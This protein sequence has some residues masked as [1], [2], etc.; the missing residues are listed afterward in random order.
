M[1]SLS[2]NQLILTTFIKHF[3]ITADYLATC[4]REHQGEDVCTFKLTSEG[5]DGISATIEVQ[6]VEGRATDE[7]LHL[8]HGDFQPTM[9]PT[10]PDF[11]YKPVPVVTPEKGGSGDCVV[12]SHVYVY[13]SFI[14]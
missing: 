5:T 6:L 11:M 7:T 13:N 14:H 3:Q 4:L 12:G 1:A 2:Y 9:T 10:D 8:K